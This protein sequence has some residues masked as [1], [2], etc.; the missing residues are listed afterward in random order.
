MQLSPDGNQ[1]FQARGDIFSVPLKMV[2]KISRAH[3]EALKEN[4]G[5]QVGKYCVLV[6][7]LGEYELYV[8][9]PVGKP[10]KN[11]QVMGPDIATPRSVA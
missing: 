7:C 11:L 8:A 3:P 10:G 4:R 6:R 5:P 9:Q 2:L 1:F